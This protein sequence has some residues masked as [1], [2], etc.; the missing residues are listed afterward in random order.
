MLAPAF[1]FC[2]EVIAH[3]MTS[4]RYCGRAHPVGV[5]CPKKPRGVPRDKGA[6]T[7]ADKWRRSR[8]WQRIREHVLDRD[9]HMCRVCFEGGRGSFP[10]ARL[11]VHHIVPLVEDYALRAEEDNLITL[12]TFH[13]KDAEAGEIPRETLR[14]L[15]EHPPRWSS[16]F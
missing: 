12:C 1:L 6:P 3:M 15:A 11:E 5:V 2:V 7:Q 13:H 16:K 10:G 4:C 14:R 8:K 9:Y